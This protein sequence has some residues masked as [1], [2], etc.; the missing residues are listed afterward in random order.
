MLVYWLT[1]VWVHSEHLCEFGDPSF[2]VCESCQP[3]LLLLA[4][5][6]VAGVVGHDEVL[7]L[8]QLGSGCKFLTPEYFLL[9][10]RLI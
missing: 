8:L 3:H 6:Y 4:Q 10:F 5:K 7:R 9:S 2:C 1:S